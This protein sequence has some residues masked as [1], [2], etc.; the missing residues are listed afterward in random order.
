MRRWGAKGFV[1]SM[2]PAFRRT[3]TDP[4]VALWWNMRPKDGLG[5]QL[6]VLAC[7]KYRLQEHNAYAIGLTLEALRMVE[8][9]GTYTL[10]QAVEGARLA[11]PAPPGNVPLNWR[12]VLGEP[13]GGLSASE[14]KLIIEN[15]YRR[16]A[17][18][19][20]GDEAALVE[21]NLAIEQAREEIGA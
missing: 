4:A 10:E 7:D 9:Y 18:E 19:K 11:L 2:A 3:L 16:A 20:R 8:R 13:P 5:P 14:T 6:R 1:L 17:M 21:L 15:R 12:K